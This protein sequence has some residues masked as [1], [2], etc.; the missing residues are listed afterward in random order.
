MRN[1]IFLFLVSC[2]V[3]QNINA[4][5]ASSV[6]NQPRQSLHKQ[7]VKHAKIE[8]VC[9]KHEVPC[10][11]NRKEKKKEI[12]L[13]GH[14]NNACCHYC[15]NSKNR[16]RGP[17]IRYLPCAGCKMSYCTFCLHKH[18]KEFIDKYKIEK[19]KHFSSCP[20]CTDVIA[21]KCC[22]QFT[23][24][25]VEHTHCF[26]YNRTSQRH[27]MV[28][29][30]KWEKKKLQIKAKKISCG[31]KRKREEDYHEKANKRIKCESLSE[32]L[33]YSGSSE[34]EEDSEFFLSL[35]D[36]DVNECY[37]NE[38]QWIP[39]EEIFELLNDQENREG[40]LQNFLEKRNREYEPITF[41]ANENGSVY[42]FLLR[43]KI[44]HGDK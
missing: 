5:D 30:L 25:N 1:I 15:R 38:K 8:K 23:L 33:G 39:E 36:T 16:K 6:R 40:N 3:C 12:I 31:Q 2:L 20:V 19:L 26:T 37:H 7:R 18:L 43:A 41:I 28:E 29:S 13:N 44:R 27:S 42:N 21:D 4:A 32:S 9:E 24:C 34:S 35:S 10:K 22:C 17:S 14:E 11:Q